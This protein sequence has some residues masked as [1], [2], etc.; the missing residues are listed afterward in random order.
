MMAKGERRV[1]RVVALGVL[2]RSA[3]RRLTH[4]IMKEHAVEQIVRHVSVEREGALVRDPSRREPMPIAQT[5]INAA[6]LRSADASR[7]TG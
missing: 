2:E 5:A 6:C 3:E 4:E 7:T 1:L